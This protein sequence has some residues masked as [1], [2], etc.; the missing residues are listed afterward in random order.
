MGW[1]RR[2][3]FLIYDFFLKVEVELKKENT[4]SEQKKREI[5]P[6]ESFIWQT[7]ENGSKS[8]MEG[9]LGGAVG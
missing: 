3:I 5:I 8:E 4:E 7:E 1:D 9:R 6:K 2:L